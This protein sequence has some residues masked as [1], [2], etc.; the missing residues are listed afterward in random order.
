MTAPS[1]LSADSLTLLDHLKA[2]NPIF[3]RFPSHH[4]FLDTLSC[5]HGLDL[6]WWPDNGPSPTLRLPWKYKGTRDLDALNNQALQFEIRR[7]RLSTSIPV[8]VLGWIDNQG[9]ECSIH[10]DQRHILKP[11]IDTLW[12]SV[13]IPLSQFTR[14]KESTELNSIES[15]QLRLEHFGEVLIDN[16]RVGPNTP[17]KKAIRKAKKAPLQPCPTGKFNLFEENFDHVWGL[18]NYGD[19][20]VFEVSPKRGRNKSN[21]LEIEW[22]YEPEPFSNV[23]PAHKDNVIGFTWNGWNPVSAP[24]NLDYSKIELH[25]RNIG[26][27]PGP[28]GALPMA[29]GLV[30]HH[31]FKSEVSLSND[32]FTNRNFGHW[33]LCTIPLSEFEWADEKQ[34]AP[35]LVSIAYI[36]ISTASQGHVF[37]DDVS[38]TLAE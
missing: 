23:T 21:T 10:L 6:I 7:K 1:A 28:K 35:G 4:V 27:N 18:G 3:G 9:H 5:S 26:V 37:I 16:L 30:D 8:L 17:N 31:G 33:E 20:R 2:D 14:G 24:G 19:H 12:Q 25:L 34:E 32:F 11:E 22:D 13:N 36:T 29:I 15:L 38:I